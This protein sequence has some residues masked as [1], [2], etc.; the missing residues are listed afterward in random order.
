[1]LKIVPKCICFYRLPQF[2]CVFLARRTF[3]LNTV[4][5][6]VSLVR[7]MYVRYTCILANATGGSAKLPG[8]KSSLQLRERPPRWHCYWFFR[9]SVII[10]RLVPVGWQGTRVALRSLIC[11]PTSTDSHGDNSR[12]GVCFSRS[13]SSLFSE[14]TRASDSRCT[15]SFP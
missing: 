12:P 7:A 13:F 8:G 3:L 6:D 15:R 9:C 2:R 1:M 11:D 14:N 10:V 5:C 4:R